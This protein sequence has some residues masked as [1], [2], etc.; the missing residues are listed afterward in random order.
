MHTGLHAPTQM[1]VQGKKRTRT[2]K[3]QSKTKAR[4]KHA[5]FTQKFHKYIKIYKGMCFAG[6]YVWQHLPQ[7]DVKKYFHNNICTC[8]PVS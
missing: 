7:E 4:T 8:Q 2:E 6:G 1:Y 5:I 3:E